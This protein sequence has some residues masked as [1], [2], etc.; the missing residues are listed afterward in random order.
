[1]TIKIYHNPRC[2]KSR[3]TLQ[4]LQDKGFTPEVIE[5][6]ENP[7]TAGELKKIVEML[8]GSVRVILRQNEDEY[9]ENGL[10]DISLSDDRIIEVMVQN[11]KL[12]ERPIVINGDKAAVGRPPENVL[13]II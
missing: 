5:Y 2:T 8:G 13:A 11:P 12:I 1:M 3:L 10:A 7:P 6:L 4:L 9:K